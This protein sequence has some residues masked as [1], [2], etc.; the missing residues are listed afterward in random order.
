M[1]VA[2]SSR[3][4]TVATIPGPPEPK[5]HDFTLT[6]DAAVDV[7]GDVKVWRRSIHFRL[8][9]EH[10]ESSTTLLHEAIERECAGELVASTSRV[11]KGH[12]GCKGA[13]PMLASLTP[14]AKG[15][16][17]A[18]KR[19]ATKPRALTH[20]M[21]A[22]V[23]AA[24]SSPELVIYTASEALAAPEAAAHGL[25]PEH[26][27]TFAEVADAASWEALAELRDAVPT[28]PPPQGSSAEGTLL[29][30]DPPPRMSVA[31]GWH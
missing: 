11:L 24:G 25:E 12:L 8:L 14:H 16:S 9:P 26:L 4:R 17:A 5:V 30:F 20:G 18:V 29:L 6:V 13:T 10:A 23:Q 7:D 22:W 27:A 2:P 15:Y 19:S 28:K 1:D 31:L 3:L 21:V